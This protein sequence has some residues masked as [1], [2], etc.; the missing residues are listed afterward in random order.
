MLRSR[1]KQDRPGD[2]LRQVRLYSKSRCARRS[3]GRDGMSYHVPPN[4]V[5]Y[6]KCGPLAEL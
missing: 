5:P 1:E 6:Q 4:A 3:A 2:L